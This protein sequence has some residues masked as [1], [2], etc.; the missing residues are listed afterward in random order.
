MTCELWQG[1]MQLSLSVYLFQIA[2]EKSCDYVLIIYIQEYERGYLNCV[3]AKRAHQVQKII[4]LN[5]ASDIVRSAKTTAYD[6][7]NN[8]SKKVQS[9]A[10]HF[11]DFFSS[12]IYFFALN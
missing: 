8:E 5:P 9:P 11:K 2:R 7:N 6:Q 4:Y 10:K 3:E 12:G 1:I